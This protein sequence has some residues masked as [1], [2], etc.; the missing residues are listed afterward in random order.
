[1][2]ILTWGIIGSVIAFIIFVLLILWTHSIYVNTNKIVDRTSILE[3]NQI[4]IT[5]STTKV[6]VLLHEGWKIKESFNEETN[7]FLASKDNKEWITID[8]AWDKYMETF[9]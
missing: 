4:E 2:S 7:F 5:E 6:S 1:M 3:D 9:K 8:K